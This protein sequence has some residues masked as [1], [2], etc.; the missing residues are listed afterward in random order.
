MAVAVKPTAPTEALVQKYQGIFDPRNGFLSKYNVE[1]MDEIEL[2][3]LSTIT[4]V[5]LLFLG[6]PG[7]GKTWAIE[8]MLRCITDAELF[9]ILL[10]KEMSADDVLGPRS[11]PALKAGK[12]E[13]MVDGFLPTAHYGYVDEVFKASPPLLNS[14]LDLM[15]KRQ[16]KIGGNVLDCRQLIAIF[17]SSNELPDREDLMAMRDRIGVTKYVHPVRSP[18]GRRRVTDIQLDF[19]EGAN[20]VDMTGVVP[21]SLDEVKQIQLE[22]AGLHVPDAT[23]ESMRE[24]QERWEQKGHPPSQRRM[25][26][27]WR[28]MKGRAWARGSDHVTN[29]DMIVCQHMAWNHPDHA[30]SAREVVLEFAN[31]FARKAARAMEALEP[32]IAK[33]DDVKKAV[34]EAGTGEPPDEVMEGAWEIMRDLRRQRREARDQVAEGQKQGHDTRDLENVLSE[35]ERAH[36]YAEKTFTGEEEK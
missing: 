24:A 14:M 21:L 7:V 30:D 10:Q 9:D 16:L 27:M 33:L 28:Y 26:Q 17:T 31:V 20:T 3:G 12:I 8:L 22:V 13:R 19:I 25:G 32:I 2:L 1:R 15:A 23:R 18:E 35:I 4:G 34:N 5:D 11:L 6:D 36:D 29:D